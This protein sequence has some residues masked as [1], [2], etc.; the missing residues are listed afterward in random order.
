MP[1]ARRQAI[2]LPTEAHL[3]VPTLPPAIFPD[4]SFSKRYAMREYDISPALR[5]EVTDWSRWW[6]QSTD[7]GR[8]GRPLSASTLAKRL[9]VRGGM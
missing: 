6:T 7:T 8:Q 2:L 4:N 5:A 3:H 1:A 9:E